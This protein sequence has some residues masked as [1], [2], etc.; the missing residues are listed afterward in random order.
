MTFTPELSDSEEEHPA[1]TNERADTATAI[2]R[3][4][5][6]TTLYALIDNDSI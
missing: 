6:I 4:F 1:R 5:L 3:F 2:F